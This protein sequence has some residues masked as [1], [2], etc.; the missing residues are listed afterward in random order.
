MQQIDSG[1]PAILSGP[2][3]SSSINMGAQNPS[4]FLVPRFPLRGLELVRFNGGVFDPGINPDLLSQAE[5][6]AMN[7]LR[8]RSGQNEPDLGMFWAERRETAKL[9]KDYS[10]DLLRLGQ[11]IARKDVGKTVSVLKDAFKVSATPK[12]ERQRLK[13]LE[14]SGIL[15]VTPK[16]VSSAGHY[17]FQS[18]S[19]AYLGYNLGV[20][21][22]TRDLADAHIRLQTGDLTTKATV[23]ARGRHGK[24][25]QYD[26]DSI[27]FIL[28]AGVVTQS[29]KG[30]YYDDYQV[31]LKAV[32]SFTESARLSRLGLTNPASLAWNATS[33]T[34]LVDKVVA[35][36]QY[37]SALSVPLEFQWMD[38]SYSHRVSCAAQML[39]TSPGGNV[40]SGRGRCAFFERKVYNDFPVPIPPLSLR[41]RDINDKTKVTAG[42]LAIDR[43]KGLFK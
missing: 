40:M 24:R 39:I 15:K 20:A 38:G 17:A 35:V 18:F 12:G 1:Q 27:S 16:G 25:P 13:R 23:T 26:E 21:P 41:H 42:L 10:E 43:L 3:S 5:V 33:L 7:K 11:A 36:G 22:L 37:L 32:P 2:V 29:S 4:L 6:K 9:F 31:V 19:D 34:F 28:K 14:R 8:D 30:V